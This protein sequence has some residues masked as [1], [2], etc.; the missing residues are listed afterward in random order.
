MKK[1]GEVKTFKR[2]KSIDCCGLEDCIQCLTFPCNPKIW[3][4]IFPDFSENSRFLSLKILQILLRFVF[5]LG[6]FIP[7]SLVLQSICFLYQ[8][9]TTIH[10]LLYLGYTY[11]TTSWKTQLLIYLNHFLTMTSL[12]ILICHILCIMVFALQSFLLGVLLNIKYLIPHIAFVSILAFYC[13]SYWKSIEQKYFVLKR[14]VYEACRDSRVSHEQI[15]TSDSQENQQLRSNER[16]KIAL[17]VVSKE[18]YEQIRGKFLPY[19]TSL[20]HFMFR[21]LWS[22][23]FSY[24]IFEILHVL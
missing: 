13:H 17:P 5:I 20:F 15:E 14:I 21:V 3:E 7:I 4:E 10:F 18:V 8:A 11:S 22:I 12:L 19:Q 1:T 2:Q 24:S 23:V 9:I 6:V 16:G